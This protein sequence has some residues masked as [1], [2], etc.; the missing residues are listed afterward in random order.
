MWGLGDLINPSLPQG[1]GVNN[2]C[3]CMLLERRTYRPTVQIR[4][5]GLWCSEEEKIEAKIG[6]VARPRG[7]FESDLLNDFHGLECVL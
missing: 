2:Q 7:Y 6:E 3:I 4:V 1:A 5:L